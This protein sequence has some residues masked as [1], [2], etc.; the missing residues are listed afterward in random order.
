[1]ARRLCSVLCL[2]LFASAATAWGQSV[3]DV[4]DE[5]VALEIT[6][7]SFQGA[8][9]TV[10]L[11]AQGA[12]RTY[13]GVALHGIVRGS[14]EDVTGEVRFAT[15]DGWGAWHPLYIVPSFTDGFFM[16]AYR[17]ADLYKGQPFEVRIVVPDGAPL[18]G[19]RAG[20]F[21]WWP[22]AALLPPRGEEDQ[23]F[24]EDNDLI[25]PPP[26]VTRSA[27]G[28]SSFRGSPIRLARPSYDF[29]T[30]HHAAGFSATTLEDGKEQ[31]KRIQD[32]HQNGRGWSDIGY[33]FVIDKGGNV[34][35]GRPFLNGNVTLESGPVLV[36]GA[37]AGGANTGN[38]GICLLGCFH[39]P[40]GGSCRDEITPEARA[41]LEV[42]LAFLSETYGVAPR[43]LRGHRDFGSTAC[44][45][46][47]NY[48]LLDDFQEAMTE[49]LLVGNQPI[50]Q[51]TVFAEV[52]P[53]GVV[54]ISWDFVEVSDIVS[55]RVVRVFGPQEEVVFEGTTVES[56]SIADANTV[57]PGEVTYRLFGIS[58]TGREQLLATTVVEIEFPTQSVLTETFPNPFQDQ[59]TIRY[60]LDDDGFVLLRL[61]DTTGREITTL[62]DG[63]VEGRRWYAHAFNA[64]GLAPGVYFAR[65]TVEG[66]AGI[67]LDETQT[68][69][70]V[71]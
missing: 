17:G 68:L 31:V 19:L 30:V 22:E 63:F 69:V 4:V 67:T 13:N 49:L 26:L 48:E 12:Q 61:Y 57:G 27:W 70:L 51:A 28:A 59:T 9:R 14:A 7:S 25:V 44:P 36:Q 45:G 38:I 8:A 23:R 33:H 54:A 18:E 2:L 58:S 24:F 32:F 64:E 39:P 52:D 16:A 47:N 5:A 1:M 40:E 6:G 43:Q 34:F 3:D 60:Y 53:D 50:G 71:R 62:A 20:V 10:T 41:S 37:H 65:L 15:D 56:L 11:R 46:D 66:F 35:Q 55:Y 21:R 42:L 29:L